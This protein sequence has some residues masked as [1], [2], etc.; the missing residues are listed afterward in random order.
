MQ[1]HHVYGG[2]GH[3]QNSCGLSH[4]GASEVGQNPYGFDSQRLSESQGSLNENYM[5]NCGQAQ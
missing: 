3:I 1:N 4:K 5:Q 2:N